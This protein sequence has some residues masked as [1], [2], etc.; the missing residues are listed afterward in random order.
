ML[1]R[2]LI[3]QIEQRIGAH[4][5]ETAMAQPVTADSLWGFQSLSDMTDVTPRLFML[6]ESASQVAQL[7]RYRPPIEEKY[8]DLFAWWLERQCRQEH[9]PQARELSQRIRQAGYLKEF[10]ELRSLP[11]NAQ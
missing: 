7:A 2:S 3:Q 9:S 11:L 1:A 6:T 8:A 10:E 4:F 5:W